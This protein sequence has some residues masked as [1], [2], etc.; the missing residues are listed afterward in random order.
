MKKKKE[1]KKKKMNQIIKLHYYGTHLLQR[2]KE[3]KNIH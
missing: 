1:K 2:Q 3:I